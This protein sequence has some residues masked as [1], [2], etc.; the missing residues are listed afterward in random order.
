[1]PPAAPVPKDLMISRARS[2]ISAS[3]TCGTERASS[4]ATCTLTN[5]RQTAAANA[6]GAMSWLM[7]GAFIANTFSVQSRQN[8][9]YVVV[10]SGQLLQAQVSPPPCRLHATAMHWAHHME[11][12]G[13]GVVQE[14]TR[15]PV[16]ARTLKLMPVEVGQARLTLP[17]WGWWCPCLLHLCLNNH[18]IRDRSAILR[19][20]SG[21]HRGS[22]DTCEATGGMRIHSRGALR[23]RRTR[24]AGN[25]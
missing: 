10:G 6:G 16:K 8:N 14:G 11:L 19:Q 13:P 2:A 4:H 25:G 7:R 3:G 18:R 5:C 22:R 1:M 21:G 20:R 24:R 12:H 23:S 17:C 9:D 15:T